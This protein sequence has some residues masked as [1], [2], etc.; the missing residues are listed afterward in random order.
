MKN[1]TFISLNIVN[2]NILLHKNYP[3]IFYWNGKTDIIDEI[4]KNSNFFNIIKKYFNCNIYDSVKLYITSLSNEDYIES[5]ISLQDLYSLNDID[6]IENGFNDLILDIFYSLYQNVFGNKYEIPI[7]ELSFDNILI[8]VYEE[9]EKKIN[10]KI[11]KET[12]IN[13]ILSTLD[14]RTKLNYKNKK[15]LIDKIQYILKES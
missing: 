7:D 12:F 2:D 8:D 6:L 10:K 4:K 3:I 1:E 5:E 14:E 9:I 15:I 11:S 13:Y